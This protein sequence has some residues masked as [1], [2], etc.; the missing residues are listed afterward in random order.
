MTPQSLLTKKNPCP[1]PRI[2]VRGS[3]R[4]SASSLA[5]INS[6]LLFLMYTVLSPGPF[7]YWLARSNSLAPYSPTLRDL[8]CGSLVHWLCVRPHLLASSLTIN[9]F[10][11]VPSVWP[12]PSSEYASPYSTVHVNEWLAACSDWSRAALAQSLYRSQRSRY[13][14]RLGAARSSPRF[15]S[16]LLVHDV[17]FCC[18]SKVHTDKTGL[19]SKNNNYLL[20]RAITFFIYLFNE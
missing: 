17:F 7:F 19:I 1:L 5:E 13:F 16:V 10:G 3:P 14:P 4:S 20:K 2:R 11:L 6:V 15:T 18:L 12:S 9:A 8:T